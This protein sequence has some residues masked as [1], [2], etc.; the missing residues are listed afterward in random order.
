[1]E[2]NKEKRE[3]TI[4]QLVSGPCNVVFTKKNGDRREMRCTLEAS[5]LP[6]LLP[7]EEGQE[8]QKRKVNPDVLAVFDLEAQGWRSFRWDSLQSINT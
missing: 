7:L 4:A 8:K 6:P 3:A 1:M 5:M 2:I